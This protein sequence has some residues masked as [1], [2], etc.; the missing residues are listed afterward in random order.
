MKPYN[1]E[2]RELM[3][4]PMKK[5]GQRDAVDSHQRDGRTCVIKSSAVVWMSSWVSMGR[6]WKVV[7]VDNVKSD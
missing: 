7:R 2:R 6:W 4:K 3:G 5:K 1:V